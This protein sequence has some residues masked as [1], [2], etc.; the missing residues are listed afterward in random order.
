MADLW[1]AEE[2][3]NTL[4]AVDGI[5]KVTS[6]NDQDNGIVGYSYEFANINALNQV[7]ASN[8]VLESV[9]GDKIAPP[10][11]QDNDENPSFTLNTKGMSRTYPSM[12]DDS[13]SAEDLAMT[14]SMMEDNFYRVTYRF[15]QKIKKVKQKG[16]KVVN[17]DAHSVT[18]E[19]SL[20]NLI[21]GKSTPDLAIKLK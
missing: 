20:A 9:G 10:A 17:Q 5:T 14:T 21:T 3:I 11:P 1:S 2:M 15:D 19:N 7:L 18:I 12:K 16:G 8:G 13:A 6:L 4:K